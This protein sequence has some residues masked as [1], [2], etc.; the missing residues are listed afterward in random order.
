[1]T[2]FLLRASLSHTSVSPHS[3]MVPKRRSESPR[4]GLLDLDHLGAEIGQ[5]GAAERRGDEGRDVEHPDAGER[6]GIGGRSGPPVFDCFKP[7]LLCRAASG[8]L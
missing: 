4:S 3:V 7:A 1:M 5:D 2:V 8:E 6:V